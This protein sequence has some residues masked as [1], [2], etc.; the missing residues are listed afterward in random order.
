[1][2]LARHA[3][4]ALLASVLASAACTPTE[5][6]SNETVPSNSVAPSATQTAALVAAYGAAM[7]PPAMDAGGVPL[8][9]DAG[10]PPP[11]VDAGSPP[12]VVDSGSPPKADAGTKPPPH[13]M[14][15]AYGGAPRPTAPATVYGGPPPVKP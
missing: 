14:A 2:P 15:P 1:M 8:V 6:T 9:V 5:S 10:A 13:P 4:V 11:I 12:P 7:P 3:R